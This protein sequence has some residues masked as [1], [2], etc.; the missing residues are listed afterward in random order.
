MKKAA[1]ILLI[2][3]IV[4]GALTVILFGI[5]GFMY[6]NPSDELISEL[7]RTGVLP[8]GAQINELRAMCAVYGVFFLVLAVLA[9][10]GIVIASITLPRLNTFPNKKASIALG[11]LNI[12]LSCTA[13]G[14]VAGI[15]I[16]AMPPKLFEQQ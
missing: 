6:V 2:L 11:V 4:F 1:K 8:T 10:G 14:I 12:V 16:L 5:L 15:L 7:I 3:S 13:C 9:I